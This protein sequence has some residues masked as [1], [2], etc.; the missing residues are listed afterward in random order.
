MER[1]RSAHS[2]RRKKFLKILLGEQKKATRKMEMDV[3]GEESRKTSADGTLSTWRK[4]F[5]T[6]KRKLKNPHEIE[7]FLSSSSC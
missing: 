2:A 5:I 6:N 1:T 7:G 4:A 3:E